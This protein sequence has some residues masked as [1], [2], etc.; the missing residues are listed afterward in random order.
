MKTRYPN[1]LVIDLLL[2]DVRRRYT[3]TPEHLLE[4]VRAQPNGQVIVIDEIQKVPELLSLVH[5][6]IEE[7]KDWQFVLTGS[8]ARKLKKQG[9]STV[10]LFIDKHCHIW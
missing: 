2:S 6:L 7:K 10:D 5:V 8:S 3:A 9:V 4:V 1:A